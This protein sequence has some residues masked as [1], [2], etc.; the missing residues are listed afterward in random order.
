MPLLSRVSGIELKATEKTS[1]S[2]SY[3]GY[4]NIN[5]TLGSMQLDEDAHN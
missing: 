3:V 4:L 5:F 2:I 1:C